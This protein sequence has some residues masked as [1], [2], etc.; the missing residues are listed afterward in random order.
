MQTL[1]P[2]REQVSEITVKINMKLKEFKE[3]QMI[4]ASLLDEQLTAELITATRE[5]IDQMTQD[6]AT[7]M[8]SYM[9]IN[10]KIWNIVQQ[11]KDDED[12]LGMS[13]K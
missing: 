8:V 1:Q 13:H 2:W 5:S 11:T 12:G 7:L 4:V 6:L 9:K 3:T 10:T